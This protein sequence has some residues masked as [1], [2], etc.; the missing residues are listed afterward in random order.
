MKY[1]YIV[2]III[3]VSSCSPWKKYQTSSYDQL[4]GSHKKVAVLPVSLMDKSVKFKWTEDQEEKLLQQESFLM[5]EKIYYALS[6]RTGHKK[7]DIKTTFQSLQTTNQKLEAGGFNYSNIDVAS[8]ESLTELLDVDAVV[9]T[10]LDAPLYLAD[11]SNEQLKGIARMAQVFIS[12][13]NINNVLGV[14]FQSAHI[15]SE[16][17]D[18][19]ESVAV[20]NYSKKHG[21]KITKPNTEVIKEISLSL[22]KRFPYRD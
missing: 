7:K 15:Q 12:D 19:K 10:S 2:L 21:I 4:S 14:D 1:P 16:I 9:R 22:A 20:W 5:Q 17:T 18:L 6:R 11:F 13:E 8:A 3:L